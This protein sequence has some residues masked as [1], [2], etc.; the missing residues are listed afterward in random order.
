MDALLFAYD[1]QCMKRAL[2]QIKD[3]TG[4]D[5]PVHLHRLIRV[6]VARLQNQ[7]IL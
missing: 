4:P 6:F 7:W 2:M 3:N 1:A 5:Q